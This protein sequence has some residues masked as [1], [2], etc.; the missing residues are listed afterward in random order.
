M[1]AGVHDSLLVGYSA[2]S[3]TKEVVLSLQPHHGSATS[4]F[5]VV[6]NGVVAHCFPA[7]LLPAIL[8]QIIPVSSEWLLTDQWPS[9]ECGYKDCGWPGPWAN[10]L[11][12]ATRFVQAS[13]LQGFQ[14][15]SSYGMSGWVLALSAGLQV[16]PNHS[17]KADGFAAA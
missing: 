5:S 11:A 10:T 16:S 4:P 6:F 14:V 2:N 15:E 3:H 7:P 8:S 1:F 13:E 17:F 9:I 12:N